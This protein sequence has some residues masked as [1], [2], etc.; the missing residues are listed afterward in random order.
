MIFMFNVIFI[1]SCV[2][3]ISA[4]YS[5]KNAD[6]WANE[7]PQCGGSLQSPIDVS[8]DLIDESDFD[9]DRKPLI[10]EN[11]Y[12]T[13]AERMTLENDGHT[14]KLLFQWPNDPEKVP[15]V[16]GGPLEDEY[17]T[18]SY[19]FRWGSDIKNGSGHQL[20]GKSYAM[21]MQAVYYN[22]E[23]GSYEE[24][25]GSKNGLAIYSLFYKLGKEFDFLTKIIEKMP[26]VFEPGTSTD[27]EP[28]ALGDYFDKN[29]PS[30]YIVYPGSL[31]HPPCTEPINWIISERIIEVSKEQV[32]AFQQL[33]LL[34]D[35]DHN[36]RPLQP[37]NG[38]IG[39]YA[40]NP[41]AYKLANP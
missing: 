9:S 38:R 31:P 33:K 5:Y 27:I 23:F 28:F 19:Q 32:R 12:D 15:Y 11:I 6:E 3:L 24:A 30:T 37:I 8:F 34:N 17:I 21:E 22:K 29:R 41:S 13:V 35:D 4:D 16:H 20:G 36:N 18:H 26:E 25:E 40:E 2:S 10:F 39:H 14:L 1:S 7:Y